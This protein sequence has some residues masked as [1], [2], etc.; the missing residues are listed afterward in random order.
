MLMLQYYVDYLV[1]KYMFHN[2]TRRGGFALPT[3]LIASVVLLSVLVAASTSVASIRTSLKAQYYEQLAKSAGEAGVA[4]A[5]ACLAQNGNI[6]QWTTAKPLTPYTDC[7]GNN[8]INPATQCPAHTRCSVVS[9]TTFRSSFKV[10]APSVDVNGRALTIPNTGYVELLRASNGA[11]WRTYN[12]PAVQ[13]A[14]VPDLCSG[15][16]GSQY[17]WSNA[18]VASG[19]VNLPGITSA[20]SIS[21]S[22]GNVVAGNT[23]FRKDFPVTE[24]G[25]YQLSYNRSSSTA[26]NIYIDGAQIGVGD[27]SSVYTVTLTPGCH[28]LTTALAS[29]S[30]LPAPAFFKLAIAKPNAEP[31]VSTDTSWRVTAGSVVDFTSPKYVDY[32]S[33]WKA[34]TNRGV[35]LSSISDWTTKTGDS[36]TMYIAPSCTTVCPMGSSTFIRDGNN[37]VLAASDDKNGDG[38]IDIVVHAFCDDTCRVYIAGNKVI[39]DAPYTVTQQTIQLE[40]GTYRIGAQLYNTGSVAT[41]PAGMGLM[42]TNKENAN[43]VLRQT[44]TSWQVA[45]NVWFAGDTAPNI[46]SSYESGYSPF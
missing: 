1:E 43:S 39:G 41:N 38:L 40:P 23:Y 13:S 42:L 16:T 35:A 19:S 10:T 21:I 22:S 5:K 25:T 30:V 26:M 15:S 27:S 3:V 44:N 28:T 20:Q 9:T 37:L 31:I 12:Q 33:V 18:A 2:F 14:V 17:G 45:D 4:Y 8:Q 11:V 7:A 24:G 36:T 46:P 34:A 29:T 32:P 6:A